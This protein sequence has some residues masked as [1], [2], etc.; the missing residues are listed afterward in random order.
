MRLEVVDSDQG[1][2]QQYRQRLRHSDPFQQCHTQAG[3][4]G[5]SDSF[6][7]GEVGFCLLEDLRQGDSVQPAGE[8][9]YNTAIVGMFCFL[10]NFFVKEEFPAPD[11]GD[12]DRAV[13]TAGFDT[14]DH[15]QYSIFTK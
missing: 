6:E 5:H 8:L 3:L 1:N 2:I 4:V 9:G 15:K 10:G 12:G 7:T 11:L 14:E 13:V